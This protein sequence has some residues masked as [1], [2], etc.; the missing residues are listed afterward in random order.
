MNIEDLRK[1][2][3]EVEAE[4]NQVESDLDA[5]VK[6]EIGKI[7]DAEIRGNAE[8]LLAS[9]KMHLKDGVKILFELMDCIELGQR[10]K[11]ESN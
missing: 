6:G 5:A 10:N 3:V 1:K 8:A 4:I 11:N 2:K 7:E 9:L